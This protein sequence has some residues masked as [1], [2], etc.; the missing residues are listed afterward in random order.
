MILRKNSICS[1]NTNY[2]GVAEA[3]FTCFFNPL[4]Y[5]VLIKLGGIRVF[6]YFPTFINPLL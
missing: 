5:I 6:S 3:V 1:I 4:K 2:A